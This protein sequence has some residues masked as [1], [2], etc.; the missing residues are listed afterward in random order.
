MPRMALVPS[1]SRAKAAA[2]AI[3]AVLTAA[4]LAMSLLNDMVGAARATA[5]EGI[6]TLAGA[7]KAA[8]EAAK[9]A[10][11]TARSIVE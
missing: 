7:W 4:T 8:T 2:G 10:R 3:M 11:T 5:R 6:C 1:G 9:R